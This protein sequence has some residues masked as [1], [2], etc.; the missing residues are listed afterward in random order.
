[1]RFAPV[2]T[3]ATPILHAAEGAARGQ[4]AEPPVLEIVSFRLSPGITDVAFLAAARGT[5]ALV[6]AQPGFIRRSLARD[7]AG[8]WT[9]LITW[10]SLPHATAAAQTVPADPAFAPF[11]AA[12]DMGSVEMRH[13]PILWQMGD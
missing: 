10:Q 12:I 5:A 1:M 4:A 9:D 6:A 3:R 8:I 2:F 11:G 7:E 13:L